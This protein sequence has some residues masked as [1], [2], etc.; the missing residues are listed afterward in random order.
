M[1]PLAAAREVAGTVGLDAG[2]AVVLHHLRTAVVHLRPS[3]VVARV[4][5]ASEEA[6][7][8]RQVEVTAH[9]ADR[10]AP[11][12]PP[13][14]SPGPYLVGD[15]A[16]TLWELIDHDGSRPLDGFAAGRALRE[17]H[18]ALVELDTRDLPVFPRLD[19]M[20]RIL[21][22][23]DVAPDDGDRPAEM[24]ALAEVAAAGIGAP[25]QAVHGDSWLGNVLRTPDGPLW[26]DFELTCVAPREL[27]L[28]CNDTSAL[29]RGRT[30]EDDAFLAGYGDHD[31]GL[32]RRLAP[33]ELTQLT[34]WTYQ[35]AADRPEYLGPAQRR[36]TLA[37][38]GLRRG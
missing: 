26:S 37:L 20:R 21:A 6:V 31:A 35:L 1:D 3:P 27:D 15:R 38:E 16:V 32:R 12:A 2:D 9:L 19:E 30:A 10:G 22:T 14:R 13:W 29:D 36:L 23:L 25:V 17:V 34:A 11:V 8:R 4:A 24:L 33:L 5:P 18:D 28:T 7:V